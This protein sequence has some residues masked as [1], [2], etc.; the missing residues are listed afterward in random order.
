MTKKDFL[1]ALLGTTA[2]LGAGL[3]A[4][5]ADA[6]TAGL[7]GGVTAIQQS[8][9]RADAA[10]FN[11]GTTAANCTTTQ[12]SAANGTIT[13]TPPAGNFVYLASLTA[14]VANNSTGA[15]SAA[16]LSTTN[17]TGAPAWLV[18]EQAAAEAVTE[19]VN[20][21]FP[22]GLKSAVPGTNVTIVPTATL[23]SGYL[24]VQVAGWFSPL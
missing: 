18:S 19:Q 10:S 3:V 11:N 17:L 24:C 21:V 9:A 6:Q 5:P 16:A 4:I 2:L 15:A 8:A 7:P 13:V 22:T 1:N 23:A 20:Q 14:Q 12:V